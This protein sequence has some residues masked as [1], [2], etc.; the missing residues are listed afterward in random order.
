M[1]AFLTWCWDANIHFF[2]QDEKYF[3]KYEA[4]IRLLFGEGIEP[5]SVDRV[6]VHVRRGKNPANINEPAYSENPFYE[7]L[8]HHVHEDMS[9]T[10][11][12]KALALFPN[13]KFT[14]FSDDIAWCKVCPLF[15]GENF[16]FSEG[17]NDVDDMNYMANHK[18]II[19][20]N[21][22]F[23][24]WAAFLGEYPGRRI[25]FPLKWFANEADEQ[26]I[27]IPDRWE[28]I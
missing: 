17:R 6:A 19:G 26:F 3:K 23:S 14:I 7:N 1:A 11:Y 9:D 16:E 10:Y 8:M 18:H 24:W 27:G 4:R 25:I 15:Q 12:A 20:A 13:E 28:R 2:A 5:N 21:S 22:S